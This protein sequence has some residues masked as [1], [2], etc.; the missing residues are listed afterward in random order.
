MKTFNVYLRDGRIAK[1][2]AETFRHDG[3]RYVFDNAGTSEAQFFVDAE[4]AGI[5]EADPPQMPEAAP[6]DKGDLPLLAKVEEEA[7]L[8]ALAECGGNRTHAAELLGI[9]RRAIYYK[10]KDIAQR[11]QEGENCT[12]EPPQPKQDTGCPSGLLTEVE[13]QGRTQTRPDSD[14][15]RRPGVELTQ[16]NKAGSRPYEQILVNKDLAVALIQS[17]PRGEKAG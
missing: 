4:I 1:V 8:Q 16:T 6:L 11:Q 17:E 2:H 3:D 15:T 10:L 14:R 13:R 5:S 9:S 12:V 7:I